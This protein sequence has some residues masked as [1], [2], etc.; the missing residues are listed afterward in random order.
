MSRQSR[1]DVPSHL[2]N[3]ARAMVLLHE[4]HLRSCIATWRRAKAAGITLPAT[5][6][7]DYASLAALLLHICRAARGYM[8]WM[9]EQLQLPDPAIDPPPALTGIEANVDAWLEH[10]LDSWRTALVPVEPERF[11]DREYPSRWQRLYTIDAMLEHAVM[12]PI[13]HQFQLEELL[14]RGKK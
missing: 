12:H 11:E 1:P 13:R 4:T 7:P 14:A 8:T 2:H 6:D 9:C 3:G 5:D 10:L